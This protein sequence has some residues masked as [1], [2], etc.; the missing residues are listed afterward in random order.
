MIIHRL[1]V[2][3]FK[4]MG[5]QIEIDFP[6]EGIIGILGRN[7]SGKST[8]LNAI[9][10][11]L[12]GLKKGKV[13]G[14][15][16]EDVIT[17]GKNKC[18]IELEFTARNKR[19]IIRREFDTTGRNTVE[20]IPLSEDEVKPITKLREAQKFI[21]DLIGMDRNSFSKII[22]IKQG[23]LDALRDLSKKDREEL[24]NKVMGIDVYDKIV[25]KVKSD[26]KTL[27]ERLNL[28]E[29]KEKI[30]REN[31]HKYKSYENRLKESEERLSDLTVEVDSLAK[32]KESLKTSLDLYK[33]KKDIENKE[34]YLR[35]LEEDVESYEQKF[36]E[37][38]HLEN[39]YTEY[40]DKY[41]KLKNLKDKCI[42]ISHEIER[43]RRSIESK[44]EQ[45]N[46][47]YIDEEKVDVLETK[48]REGIVKKSKYKKI[49]ILHSLLTIAT[50]L[51][52][53][54][55]FPDMYIISILLSLSLISGLLILR[56]HS[57]Y[58]SLI[59]NYNKGVIIIYE[60]DEMHKDLNN[61]ESELRNLL[62]EHGYNSI[63]EVSNEL[64]EIINII[65]SQTGFEEIEKLSWR[66]STL[67]AE[68]KNFD[69]TK[70][71]QDID[72]VRNELDQ[73]NRQ[74]EEFSQKEILLEI[75]DEDYEEYKEKFNE[76]VD[77][78][79]E[80]E[81][82]LIKLQKEI[83]T[84]KEELSSLEA[85]YQEYPKIVEEIEKL[86]SEIRVKNSL[87]EAINKVAASLR[88][89]VLPRASLAIS[90]VL[91]DITEGRYSDLSI[92][93]DLKFKVY[94]MDAGGYKEREVFSGGTQ[95][96]FLIA[97]RLAFTESLLD[98]KVGPERYCLIM[99]ECIS[100]SDEIRRRNILNTIKSMKE[101]FSQIFLVA[102]I[103]ISAYV[104]HYIRLERGPDGYTK[105]VKKSW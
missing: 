2:E 7:E 1:K 69:I 63:E 20:I 22:Y 64:E 71:M 79:S 29:E 24:I 68:I 91:P 77:A 85:D 86:K 37:L 25:K 94:S 26:V 17:W 87:K 36:E 41:E 16:R 67:K 97:L 49:L 11:A 105:I 60:I 81:R 21:E 38:N 75:S 61:K 5:S 40:G 101:T 89:S 62:S 4:I 84:I 92:S 80:K 9:E 10:Y 28:L 57:R 58:S 100:S 66:I 56:K 78:H 98:L 99:D 14:E 34:K 93:E 6:D 53:Y 76:L 46:R 52:V 55:V 102:H 48:I 8:L 51:G 70:D 27:E 73:L 72:L 83:E 96:Q 88:S 23:E 39:I 103:D 3:G 74:L 43:T 104:D 13:P 35:K 50:I 33:L 44:K 18:R 54:L 90:R 32:E 12:F 19:F 59:S 47:F 31:Y 95:D 42:E 45:L 82:G 30:L 65:E 15:V